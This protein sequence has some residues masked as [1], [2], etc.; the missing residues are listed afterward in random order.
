MHV[1]QL[2]FCRTRSKHAFKTWLQYFVLRI[3]AF[4]ALD[5]P[6]ILT[7]WE[8]L[9]KRISVKSVNNAKNYIRYIWKPDFVSQNIFSKNF[10][11]IH[12]IKA[13]LGT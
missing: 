2:T 1:Q 8:N 3:C 10:V 13:S 7:L 6:R 9:R 4:S 12:E 11:A 5:Y